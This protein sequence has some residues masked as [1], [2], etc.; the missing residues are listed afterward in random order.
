MSK[1]KCVSIND[2]HLDIIK[3]DLNKHL[4]IYDIQTYFP[5]LSLFFD[6]Y[7]DSNK[8]FILKSKNLN[9][10]IKIK[11]DDITNIDELKNLVLNINV[12]QGVIE[13]SDSNIIWKDACKI[14]LSE[15]TL[16]Y[17][18]EEINLI[19]KFIFKFKDLNNLYSTFQINKNNR[20][21][22]EIV[23]IDFVYNFNQKKISFD[24]VKIENTPNENLQKFLDEFNSKDRKIFN[25]ITFK[26][27]VNNF[28]RVYAG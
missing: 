16:I 28:F 6:F 21:K 4:D 23:E 13:L 24:N 12:D 7:N 5:I 9:A 22:I 17:D 15:S 20:K 26:N 2:E 18:G 25:K 19:G 1:I 27:F 14:M 8:H 3:K 10:N 11:V